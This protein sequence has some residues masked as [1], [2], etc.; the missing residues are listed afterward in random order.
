MVSHEQ[1]KI[2]NM[3]MANSN[4]KKVLLLLSGGQDSKKAIQNLLQDQWRVYALC[5]DGIQGNEKLG[6]KQAALE[7]AIPI[8]IIKISFFD[9]TTWN[10]IKLIYRDLA[11]AYWAIRTA[12][13]IG[14]TA[15]ATGVKQSDVND[16]R[17]WW[18][19]YFIQCCHLLG[20]V[21]NLKLIFPVY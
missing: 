10:P 7:F 13:R 3:D 14:A 4:S 12:K 20:R 5:I 6:A 17:L 19:K 9:E 2:L 1:L 21:L 11:M 8:E 18:L 15:I 16:P